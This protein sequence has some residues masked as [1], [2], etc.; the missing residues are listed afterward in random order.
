MTE[1]LVKTRDFIEGMGTGAGRSRGRGSLPELANLFGFTSVFG[2]VS[3]LP[4][5]RPSDVPSNI[6]V[7]RMPSE[8][9]RR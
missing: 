2:G 6:L 1:H 3:P 8:W 4:H 5:T 9:M 7:Q